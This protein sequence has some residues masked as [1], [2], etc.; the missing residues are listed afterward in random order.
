MPR[1][2]FSLSP[3]ALL[4]DNKMRAAP[5]R[6]AVPETVFPRPSMAAGTMAP[7]AA[8]PPTERDADLVLLGGDVHTMDPARPRAR[9]VAFGGGR[10]LA[11]GTDA[12]AERWAGRSTEAVDLGGRVVVPGFIDAHAHLMDSAARVSN[13]RL[14]GAASLEATVRILQGGLARARAGEWLVGD[15]WDESAWP[16]ARYLDRRDLDRVSTTVPVA[17][18]RVDRHM[19]SVNS[20][21]LGLLKVPPDTR[22]LERDPSGAPT[23][24]LKEEAFDWMRHALAPT[25]ERLA[26]D[27]ARV[28]RR[29]LSLGMTSI[30]DVVGEVG[31]RAYQMVNAHGR[32][33]LRVELMARDLLL[34]HLA[35]AGLRR[36]FGDERL[37][38]GAVKAFADGSLGA[39]TAALLEPYADAPG[40]TGMLVHPPQELRE[41]VAGIHAAGFPAAVHAIGDRAIGHV[42]D[43]IEAAAPRRGA[44]HRVEHAELPLPEDVR[45]MARLGIA[46][47]AQPNFVGQWSLPG[48]MYEAR[49]GRERFR[50]NNP[51]RDLLRAGVR[52]A[53][54]SDGMPYGPLEGI[55]WAV[56]APF[57]G[58]RL[59]VDQAFAAYTAGGAWA[60]FEEAEKGALAPGALGDAVVLDGDPWRE[61]GRIRGMRAAMTIVS[62]RVVFRGRAG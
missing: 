45:R 1:R 33:P 62:G 23:G 11:V 8:S 55:H 37:R 26:R 36:G 19:A 47:V 32:L 9:A 35:A 59:T 50:G 21:A 39:R 25:D 60:G 53:F 43:A 13:L 14:G 6:E 15:D 22:G 3:A 51:Y 52:L 2:L 44:R 5:G 12:Q 54:G 38:L 4:L 49:L 42:L 56:N 20:P 31:M 58:Q 18:V 29:A 7:R 10:I 17:A 46:A 34:P 16:E 28:A 61:P 24:V 40:E 48:G 41:L 27:F 30:H 57:D